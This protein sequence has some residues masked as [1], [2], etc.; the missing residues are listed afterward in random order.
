MRLLA[1]WVLAVA[2]SACAKTPPQIPEQYWEDVVTIEEVEAADR[3]ERAQSTAQV[4][5]SVR[6][7]AD[8]S[9]V[10]LTEKEQEE[11][12]ASI[13]SSGIG[14][15]EEWKTL[16]K[17]HRPGDK[18]YKFAWPPLS[19]PFGYVLVRDGEEIHPVYVGDQ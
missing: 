7:L 1:I 15:N 10:P 14:N 11:S 17:M 4:G 9:M 18:I 13:A 16:R 8:G 19:G 5:S 3:A 6:V 12:R 2:L